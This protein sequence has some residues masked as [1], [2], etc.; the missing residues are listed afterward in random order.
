MKVLLKRSFNR[1]QIRL[2][3][4]FTIKTPVMVLKTAK[5]DLDDGC[6]GERVKI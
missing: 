3:K 5:E 2:K 6:A 1:L 4:P